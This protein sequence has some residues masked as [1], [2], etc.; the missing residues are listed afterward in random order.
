MVEYR[1]SNSYVI[2]GGEVGSFGAGGTPNT[3]IGIVTNFSPSFKNTNLRLHGVGDGRNA[4]L[5]AYGMLE[6]TGTVDFQVIDFNFFRH[7][8]GPRTGSGTSG[9]PYVLTEADNYSQSASSGIQIFTMEAAGYDETTDDVET[10]KGCWINSATLNFSLDTPLN[11]SV[12]WGASTVTGGTSAAGYTAN[13]RVPYL[14]QSGTFSWGTT[15]TAV[16]RVQSGSITIYNN[17]VIMREVGSRFVTGVAAG[18]RMYDFT[19]ELI[20]T[21]ALRATLE[22]DLYGQAVASGPATGIAAASPPANRELALVFTISGTDTAQI[23][24]NDCYIEERTKPIPIGNELIRVTYTGWAHS[25]GNTA[26]TNQPLR[27]WTS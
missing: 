15:P 23:L 1:P 27:W 20:M 21:D 4:I 5:T 24:L 6:L 22:Q 2:Y 18:Q 10:Y 19:V 25:G 9:A 7:L 16:T 8:I 11:A 17:P 3:N 12:N 13:T 14:M 26:N